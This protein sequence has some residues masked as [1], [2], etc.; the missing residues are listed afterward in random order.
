MFT[1]GLDID[2]R[3]YFTAATII[4]AK[5]KRFFLKK[6]IILKKDSAK[7]AQVGFQEPGSNFVIISN[8]LND[9]NATPAQKESVLAKFNFNKEKDSIQM[10]YELTKKEMDFF[11]IIIKLLL[12]QD[13]THYNP[14]QISYIARDI[15][16]LGK[17]QGRSTKYN[18]LMLNFIKACAGNTDH[19]YGQFKLVFIYSLKSV[20]QQTLLSAPEKGQKATGFIKKVADKFFK[21]IYD[22]TPD[23]NYF[24]LTK[25]K[26]NFAK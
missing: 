8:I 23:N 15:S 13:A 3:A 9:D 25:D 20:I 5:K 4:M 16:L 21:Q 19:S 26:D 6:K 22:I 11:S 12:V 10:K 2:T 1:V 18:I 17:K 24:V 14:V 7:S